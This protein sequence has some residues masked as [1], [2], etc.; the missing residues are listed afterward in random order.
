M[1]QS[2]ELQS[3]LAMWRAKAATDDLTVEE[4][5]EA[6]KLLR[7]DRRAAADAPKATKGKA[8]GPTKSADE[9]LG[10]LEGL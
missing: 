10:E 5:R 1:L 6:I 3:K 8:K 7:Q 4:M 2:P 9:M